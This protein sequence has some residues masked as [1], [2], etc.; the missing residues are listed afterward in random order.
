MGYKARVD[1]FA[2]TYK[3]KYKMELVDYMMGQS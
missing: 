2:S 3:S 1:F